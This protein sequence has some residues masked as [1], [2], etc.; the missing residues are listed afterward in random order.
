MT[1]S[2]LGLGSAV[3]AMLLAACAGTG[4]AGQDARVV[5]RQ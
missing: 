2:M 5:L 4:G 3:M 1:R